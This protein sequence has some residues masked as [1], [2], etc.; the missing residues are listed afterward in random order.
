MCYAC[1]GAKSY[2]KRVMP[3]LRAKTYLNVLPL[4]LELN[5][6]LTRYACHR[7]KSYQKRVMTVTELNHTKNVLRLSGS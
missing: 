1:L 5:L 4:Q 6:T 2:Q 3:V 7:A